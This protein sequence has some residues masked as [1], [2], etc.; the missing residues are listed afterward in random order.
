[1]VTKVNVDECVGCGLCEDVCPSGA[2]A[3]DDVAVIDP[4]KCTDCGKCIDECPN[5]CLSK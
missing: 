3:V 1:M 2:L 5:D 4:K